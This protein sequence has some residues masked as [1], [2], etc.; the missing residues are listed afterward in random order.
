MKTVYLALVV[1]PINVLNVFPEKKRKEHFALTK[2]MSKLRLLIRHLIKPAVFQLKLL[3]LTS[4][5]LLEYQHVEIL[6]ILSQILHGNNVKINVCKKI[7]MQYPIVQ[8]LISV[9]HV[10]CIKIANQHNI[11]PNMDQIVN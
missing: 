9:H 5:K 10:Y 7:A 11:R 3:T 6:F 8:S 2:L 4:K 1:E